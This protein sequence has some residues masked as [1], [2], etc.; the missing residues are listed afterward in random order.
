VCVSA[1]AIT[2]RCVDSYESA[3]SFVSIKAIPGLISKS[4]ANHYLRFVATSRL[5]FSF[6]GATY[7]SCIRFV[8][9]RNTPDERSHR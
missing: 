3:K 4:S 1:E 2:N 8:P 5:D 9:V 7:H 6:G